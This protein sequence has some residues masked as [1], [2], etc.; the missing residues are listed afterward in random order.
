[1]NSK[2]NCILNRLRD[3]TIE[4]PG[5]EE[6]TIKGVRVAR[7]FRNIEL[8]V[9]RNGKLKSLRIGIT[10]FLKSAIIKKDM[11]RNSVIAFCLLFCCFIGLG[12]CKSRPSQKTDY[13]FTLKDSLFWEREL[14]DT[15]VKIPYSIANLVINPQKME[16]G[17]KRETS[18]GQA[19]L[20]VQKKGDTIVIVASC[21][22]LELVVKSLKER[23][24]KVSEE[25]ENLK[26]EVKAAP[27]RLLSFMG[28]IGMGAFTVLIAL[29]ILLKVTK[30]I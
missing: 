19:N 24:S 18:K 7:D 5:I 4:L 10:G 13:N 20:S 23:L 12:G 9:I 6:A 27:N 2:N 16:D 29:F 26:E 15:L 21:D 30:R 28:G 22:S 25:N 1:M 17:E 3:K 11:R 8:D 14:T